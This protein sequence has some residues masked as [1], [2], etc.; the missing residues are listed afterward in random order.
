MNLSELWNKF[1]KIV[2]LSIANDLQKTWICCSIFF[3]PEKQ[4]KCCLFFSCNGDI[5]GEH[6][7]LSYSELLRLQFSTC[8]MFLLRHIIIYQNLPFIF[9][10]FLLIFG[11]SYC[12]LYHDYQTE[13]F[14]TAY[15]LDI[16]FLNSLLIF[17]DF[18]VLVYCNG[19][20]IGQ[21]ISA[22]EA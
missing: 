2:C 17:R 5:S 4:N 16:Q 21:L 9:P 14:P 11:Q 15:H 7:L 18:H 8:S 19:F 13:D 20:P 6:Y 10:L 22:L 3:C 12:L 1:Q